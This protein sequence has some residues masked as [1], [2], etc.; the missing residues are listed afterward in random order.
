[1]RQPTPEDEARR[2]K[3]FHDANKRWPL[4]LSDRARLKEVNDIFE[5]AVRALVQPKSDAGT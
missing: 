2:L 5:R 1:M 4:P 3:A